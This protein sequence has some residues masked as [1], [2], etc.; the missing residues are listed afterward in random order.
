MVKKEMTELKHVLVPRQDRKDMDEFVGVIE[1]L[2]SP[3]TVF[4]KLSDVEQGKKSIRF[5]TYSAGK[6]RVLFWGTYHTRDD[7]AEISNSCKYGTPGAKLSSVVNHSE[8]QGFRYA[9][10]VTKN[11]IAATMSQMQGGEPHPTE[12]PEKYRVFK[13][14]LQELDGK[15]TKKDIDMKIRNQIQD[16]FQAFLDRQRDWDEKRILA[17]GT[18]KLKQDFEQHARDFVEVYESSVNIQGYNM[19][20]QQFETIQHLVSKITNL[21]KYGR[22]YKDAVYE[23]LESCPLESTCEI[24]D[25]NQEPLCNMW[26]FGSDDELDSLI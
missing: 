20:I 26:E 17:E 23:A 4:V 13:Y 19:S 14:F 9:G 16:E 5:I 18:E 24:L 21:V 7:Q 11:R 1:S 22:F 2:S 6:H 25:K 15:I 10:N 3:F 12:F 8:N